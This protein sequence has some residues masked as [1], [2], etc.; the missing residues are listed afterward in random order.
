MGLVCEGHVAVGLFLHYRATL[1]IEWGCPAQ[2]ANPRKAVAREHRVLLSPLHCWLL[3][4][5]NE[6]WH[7][8]P[9]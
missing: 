4:G 5:D 2:W 1:L 3:N 7:I 8:H 6:A 9:F